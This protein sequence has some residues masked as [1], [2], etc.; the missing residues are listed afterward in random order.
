MGNFS[1]IDRNMFNRNFGSFSGTPGGKGMEY[2]L[3]IANQKL[4]DEYYASRGLRP[5]GSPMPDTIGAHA[6]GSAGGQNMNKPWHNPK[7]AARNM[8]GGGGG[9][10]PS[11]PGAKGTGG[12][13]LEPNTGSNLDLAVNQS[14]RLGTESDHEGKALQMGAQGYTMDVDKGITTTPTGA[15]QMG[16]YNNMWQGAEVIG[17][18]ATAAK[19]L[20]SQTPAAPA[21]TTP[22]Q[23]KS[24][25]DINK[26]Q[27][28][29]AGTG[30]NDDDPFTEELL[31]M[32]FSQYGMGGGPVPTLGGAGTIMP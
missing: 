16:S 20:A 5:D 10:A 26:S 18:P 28:Q 32:Y 15:K 27:V 8:G 13:P 24:N 25:A 14:N 2:V 3:A 22:G 19:Q 11:L 6:R 12:K 7:P 9:G 23:P 31:N 30:G 1:L 21:A 4:K 29:E 17:P